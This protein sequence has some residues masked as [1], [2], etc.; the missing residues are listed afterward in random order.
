MSSPR[1]SEWDSNHFGFKV[2]KADITSLAEILPAL[3]FC[4]KEKVKLLI[5]RCDASHISHVHLLEKQGLRL[6]DTLVRYHLN[7]ADVQLTP[8]SGSVT[9]R[10]YQKEDI[11]SIAGIAETAF[12]GY[13]SHFHSD[14]K[15]D[16]AKCDAL[17]IQWATNSCYDKSVAQEVLVAETDGEMAGFITIEMIGPKVGDLALSAV[18]PKA[19]GKG[20][21]RK[22]IISGVNW[23]K[24][25]GLDRVETGTQVNNHVVQKVW[26]DLGF[27]LSGSFYTLHGWF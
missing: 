5:C 17:Y 25:E 27:R 15:L 16:A 21:Y 19:Q 1:I 23:C 2:A 7:L 22:L 13:F 24:S 3:K 11:E 9:I 26:S 10:P 14:P 20:I 8:V 4:S 12:T 6:M 18:H